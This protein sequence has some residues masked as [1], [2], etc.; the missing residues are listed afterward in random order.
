MML[1][2][3][4]YKKE[5]LDGNNIPFEDIKKNMQEL[6]FINQWLGGHS[7][8]LDGFKELAGS[9]KEVTVCE[10]G[11]GGGDN[12]L[13][14][15]KWCSAN[16]ITVKLTGIDIKDECIQ[17]A[18]GRKE[19]SK[20]TRWILSDYKKVTFTDEPDII[21]SSLF[22]HHFSEDELTFQLNWM[23]QNCKHGFFINDLH[24]NWLAYYSIK[25]LTHLFS[26]SY[27]VKNDAPLSVAR[28]FV[29]SELEELCLKS[30]VDAS[31]KWRWAFRYLIIYKKDTFIAI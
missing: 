29:K 20:V 5:L 8:T 31:I 3:R 24:R 7:I 6:N 2:Q 27:L 25:F 13:A 22:C 23:K 30:K 28:G 11:C 1:S 18:Q 21:F 10:L 4:S 19:L 16:N 14:I 12:L 17:F 26:S 9:L 15:Y